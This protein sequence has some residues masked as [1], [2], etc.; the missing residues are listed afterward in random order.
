MNRRQQCRFCGRSARLDQGGFCARCLPERIDASK[1]LHPD[2]GPIVTQFSEDGKWAEVVPECLV[3][4]RYNA[5][6][7]LAQAILDGDEGRADWKWKR[8]I[9]RAHRAWVRKKVREYSRPCNVFIR[10]HQ[11]IESGTPQMETLKRLCPKGW[12]IFCTGRPLVA[13]CIVPRLKRALRRWLRE[14]LAQAVARAERA[15]AEHA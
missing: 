9:R 11:R 3:T 14:D 12:L 15:V 2:P 7:F 10:R 1:A 5:K 13:V 4:A 8:R 6:R